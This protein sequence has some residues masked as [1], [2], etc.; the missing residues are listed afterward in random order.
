[1]DPNSVLKT[2]VLA[3]NQYAN[4]SSDSNLINLERQ[5]DNLINLTAPGR[6]LK[7]FSPKQILPTECL[8][9]LMDILS[10]PSSPNELLIKVITVLQNL[11]SDA[12][13]K[14]VLHTTYHVTPSVA[15]ILLQHSKSPTDKIVVKSV[16]LL[17]R[18]TYNCRVPYP[19]SYA[20]EL[21]KFLITHI[22]STENE[23]TL[24][25][26]GLLAN[27][28]R[29]NVSVQ[30]HIKSMDNVKSVYKSLIQYL[31]HSNLTMVVFALSIIT[32]LCLNEELGDKLFQPKNVNQTFQLI[33]N[34]LI[35]GDDI[36]TRG[37]VVD[38][39]VSL[40]KSPKIQQSLLVFGH[41]TSG[42]QAVL[43]LLCQ[44]RNNQ[45]EAIAKIF[46]LLLAFCSSSSIRCTVCQT[47]MSSPVLQ[48]SDV[49]PQQ[50][51]QANTTEPYYAILHYIRQSYNTC[52]NVPL[53]ALEFLKEVYEE[54]FDSGMTSQLSP[55]TDLLL[56]VLS[57]Q[58]YP[59]TESD[60]RALKHY[61][62]K[63]V[64]TVDLFQVLASEDSLLSAVAQTF[65]L[66]MCVSILEH[67]LNHNSTG[68]TIGKTNCTAE[69][70][71][72]GVDVVL[73]MLELMK[74]LQ[75][76]VQGLGKHLQMTLQDGRL[77]PFLASALTSD[78]R[79]K[80]QLA[81]QL[82]SYAGKLPDFSVIVLG[83]SIAANNASKRVELESLRKPV[84]METSPSISPP[85]RGHA[86][87]K[88]LNFETGSAA[89][90][91]NGVKTNP[92]PHDSN[93]QSLIDRM[94]SGLE[95]KDMKASE[96]MDVYEHKLA[97]LATKESHLQ[98]LLEAKAMALAQ[99]DRLISQYR[100]RRAQSEAEARKLRS[101]LQ[102]AEKRNEEFIEKLNEA[103]LEQNRTA[104]EME[105][106]VSHNQR[107][108][109]I[110]ADHEKLVVQHQ[111]QTKI[112]ETTERKL[113][114]KE[115]DNAS[116]Q[117]L[118]D[119]LQRHNETLANQHEVATE[120]LAKLD[121]E[122]KNL[123]KILKDREQ[124]CTELKDKSDKQDKEIRKLTRELEN[125]DSAIE[126][127]REDL[128]KC[129][130]ERKEFKQQASVSE[131][132]NKE[133][134]TM[135]HKLRSELEKQT[136]IAKMIHSLTSGNVPESN[137]KL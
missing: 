113:K 136:Q 51:M 37:Y 137:V 59:P 48:N 66:K 81:L 86:S 110:A 75:D 95:I 22:Q 96:I 47:L 130:Q 69:W 115:E 68:M 106:L 32:S 62:H 122:R 101:L 26:F 70:S 114:A 17:Q 6:S 104:V 108:Q 18:I 14:D 99:A 55:R 21:F 42:I 46:E 134:D 133:K 118:Y 7:F 116:L 13:I 64:K 127:L 98:D 24:P 9:C 103:R 67:Q 1:M 45:P 53:L 5:L 39:F 10:E 87:V 11:A 131:K 31:S 107:L 28:C 71:D 94:Q 60:D 54:M 80:V 82:I 73:H 97:S 89:V 93:I 111:E 30:T 23:L 35:Q 132:E 120:R 124:K 121:E 3:A 117:E 41:L 83:D 56:P 4:N 15:H 112:L 77:L 91:E 65:D 78:T 100:C 74:K 76:E 25:C 79:T 63:I 16:Q 50:T 57:E 84:H 90:R 2:A 40:M 119:M 129:E 52:D 109:G 29:S 102:D 38:L 34:I 126:K 85:R 135:I 27:F 8:T 12:E 44:P 19:S 43:N 123:S 92:G 49:V 72:A 58:M 61:C 88:Q 36:T 128:S 125:S 20:D 33:F 105:Q